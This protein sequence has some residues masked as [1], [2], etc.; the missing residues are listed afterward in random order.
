ML[1]SVGRRA[2]R[3]RTCGRELHAS[4][5]RRSASCL[6][7]EWR[8]LRVR[9]R[10]RSRIVRPVPV[11]AARGRSARRVRLASDASDLRRYGAARACRSP[12]RSRR[13]RDGH[14]RS[15]AKRPQSF[16][17][18]L[19]EAFGHGS[20]VLLVL[21]FFTCGFHIAFITVHLPPYLVDG[22]RRVVGRLGARLHRPVQHLRRDCRRHARRQAAQTLSA[23]DHLPLR[24]VAIAGLPARADDARE[25]TDLRFRDGRAVALDRSADLRLSS[26]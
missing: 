9:R 26:R 17:E 11:L 7:E 22:A 25:R 2:G 21:G 6:P 13:P 5:L 4:C 24:A 12:S 19:G 20:Y 18:A 14:G 10:H 16:R 23:F 8:A 15:A 3:L 1:T